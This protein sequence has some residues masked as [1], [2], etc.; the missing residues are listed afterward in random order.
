MQLTRSVQAASVYNVNNLQ[1]IILFI[2]SQENKREECVLKVMTACTDDVA[3]GIS[4]TVS[5]STFV[6]SLISVSSSAP[7]HP[8]PGSN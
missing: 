3:L 4:A 7:K 1:A 2:Y 6:F 8:G 5:I